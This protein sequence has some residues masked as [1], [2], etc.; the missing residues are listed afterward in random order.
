MAEMN[1]PVSAPESKKI[2][3]IKILLAILLFSLAGIL[4]LHFFYGSSIK[5]GSNSTAPEEFLITYKPSNFKVN[6]DEKEAISILTNPEKYPEEFDNLVYRMNIA[7]IQ[8]VGSRMNLQQSLVNKMVDIYKGN[9]HRELRS[10]YYRDFIAAKDTSSSLY[11][12]WYENEAINA[13]EKIHIIASKYTCFLMQQV[14]SEVLQ[15]SSGKFY[16]KGTKVED[17]CGVA[18]TEALQPMIKQLEE[19]AAIEDFGRSQGILEEKVSRVIAELATY[20]QR[21]KKGL[22]Q[23][24]QTKFLGMAVS[25]TDVQI[26]AISVIKT[27]FR[28]DE[29]FHLELNEKSRVVNLTLAEPVVLSHEVYPRID[30]MEIGWMRELQGIDLNRNINLLREE[31]RREAIEEDRVLEKAKTQAIELLN[32]MFLPLIQAFDPKFS[33]KINFEHKTEIGNSN[34]SFPN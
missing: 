11:Q 8:H 1:Q 19:R 9:F 30:K 2:R 34:Y 29:Y 18:L 32:T 5:V 28:L 14:L 4:V 12:S 31:F 33:L 3:L 7:I 13:V 27:G 21:D 24:L 6:L 16:A 25:T 17:P 23:Q 10:W 20:E 15:T 22:S 26:S